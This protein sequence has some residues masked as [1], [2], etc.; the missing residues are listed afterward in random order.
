MPLAEQ[1]VEHWQEILRINLIGAFLAVK[2][3][4]PHLVKQG[5]GAILSRPPSPD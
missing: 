4:S 1:T 3:A 5:H 2:Y